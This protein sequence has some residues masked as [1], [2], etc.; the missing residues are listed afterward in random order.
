MEFSTADL[1]TSCTASTVHQI[2]INDIQIVDSI[3]GLILDDGTF[4][5]ISLRNSIN[6]DCNCSRTAKQIH[7][8]IVKC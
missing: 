1:A 7:S 6:N 3:N 5:D 8:Y 4:Y 2:G